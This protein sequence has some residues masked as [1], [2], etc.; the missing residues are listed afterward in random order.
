MDL[1]IECPVRRVAVAGEFHQVVLPVAVGV[2]CL[3]D[4][5]GIRDAGKEG[6][7]PDIE[8]GLSGGRDIEHDRGGLQV[9][10]RVLGDEIDVVG[11]AGGQAGDRRGAFGAGC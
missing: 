11:R 3:T 4:D 6:G 10:S 7:D 5:Q 1:G 9:G 8:G 2:R